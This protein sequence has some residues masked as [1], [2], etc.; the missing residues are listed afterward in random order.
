MNRSEQLKAERN[1][2]SKKIAEINRNK[3][4]ASADFQKMRAVGLEIKELYDKVDEF[5]EKKE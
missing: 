2:V 5:T 4:D 1:T 3:E